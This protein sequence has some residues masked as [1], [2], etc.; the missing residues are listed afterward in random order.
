VQH[1]A[2]TVLSAAAEEMGFD[3]T[4]IRTGGCHITKAPFAIAR[5]ISPTKSAPFLN[6]AELGRFRRQQNLLISFELKSEGML[7]VF[8][9]WRV[10][11]KLRGGGG[12]MGLGEEMYWENNNMME[13]RLAYLHAGEE[14][15]RY[16]RTRE[17]MH[18]HTYGE[19]MAEMRRET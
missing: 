4:L 18:G 2:E 5:A 14:L 10:T 11:G 13:V 19:P 15:D 7:K 3:F 9:I 12:E 17:R 6:P 16:R 1:K 8:W